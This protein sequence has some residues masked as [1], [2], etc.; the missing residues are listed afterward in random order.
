MSAQILRLKTANSGTSV[1]ATETDILW[2]GTANQSISFASI[3]MDV[4]S[5]QTLSFRLA[6]ATTALN[7]LKVY[8][9]IHKDDD[10]WIPLILTAADYTGGENNFVRYAQ[11]YDTDDVKVDKDLSTIAAT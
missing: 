2:S 7:S 11:V 4:K 10:V 9:K 6:V 8:G 3:S 1:T 5:I